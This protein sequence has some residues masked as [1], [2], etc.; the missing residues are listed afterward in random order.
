MEKVECSHV[1]KDCDDVCGQIRLDPV[2]TGCAAQE[3][4]NCCAGIGQCSRMGFFMCNLDALS[5]FIG[6]A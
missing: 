1:I 3:C 6:E 2:R 5:I 4:L